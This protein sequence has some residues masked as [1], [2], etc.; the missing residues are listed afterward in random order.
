ARDIQAWE[1]Q[2]LGPFLGKSFLTT[3]SPWVVT[4]EA[5]APFRT[6]QAARPAGGPAPLPYLCDAADQATGALDIELEG[7]LLTPGLKSKALPPQ[8]LSGGNTRHLY[9]TVAP[10]GA[11]PSRAGSKLR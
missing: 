3:I 2:P 8:R 6:A 10:L 1:Y 5:L 4:P 7:F 9:W 11:H